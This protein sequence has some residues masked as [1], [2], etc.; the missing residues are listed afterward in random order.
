VKKEKEVVPKKNKKKLVTD[1]KR[2]IEEIL[3]FLKT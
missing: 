1:L 3:R 2:S